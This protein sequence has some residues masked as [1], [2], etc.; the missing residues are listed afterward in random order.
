MAPTKKKSKATKKKIQTKVLVTG[1]LGFIGSK[2]VEKLQKANYEVE[3]VDALTTYGLLDKDELEYLYNERLKLFREDTKIHKIDIAE[4]DAMNAVFQQFKPDYVM[5]LA[6][7]PNEKLTK[8]N[9]VEAAHTMCQGLATVLDNCVRHDVKK[10]MYTSSSMVLGSFSDDTSPDGVTEFHN[11]NPQ[12][13]YAIWK[14]AGEQIVKQF[15]KESDLDYVIVRPSAVYGPLDNGNR[16]I[17][18]FLI[19]AMRDRTLSVHGIEEKLDFTYVDDLADGMIKSILKG[20][21]DTYN[22]TR[23]KSITIKD[24]AIAVTSTVGKG[25][26][27]IKDKDKDQPSRG[28]LNIDKAKTDLKFNPK[29]DIE[30]GIKLYYEW[31]KDSVYWSSK[32]V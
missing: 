12:G 31:I 7:F 10:I 14:H 22:L 2:V 30:K 26:V 17:A 21:N 8:E 6:S 3:V 13:S 23:G 9:P 16:V 28:T 27:G 15:A 24:A 4:I 1:G 5:H 20:K 11:T 25:S 19:N 18:K 32:T 29:I